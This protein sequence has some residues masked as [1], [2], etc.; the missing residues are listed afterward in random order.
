[1][2]RI[3]SPCEPVTTDDGLVLW[4]VP[5]GAL[6]WVRD[7][8]VTEWQRA[9]LRLVDSAGHDTLRTAVSGPPEAITRWLASWKRDFDATTTFPSFIG[10]YVTV[11][12]F[13]E[14]TA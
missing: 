7:E 3:A 9:E 14:E 5:D 10:F 2:V 6:G 1:M 8:P 12:P 13:I 4:H 11:S